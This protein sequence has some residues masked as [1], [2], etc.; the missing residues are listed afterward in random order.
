M[1]MHKICTKMN[2]KQDHSIHSEQ[3]KRKKGKGH[4]RISIKF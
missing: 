1:Y 4:F 2:S 3:T